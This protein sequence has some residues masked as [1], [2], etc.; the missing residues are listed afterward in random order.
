MI[1]KFCKRQEE[2]NQITHKKEN[3]GMEFEE[4]FSRREK[5][6]FNQSVVNAEERNLKSCAPT[7]C[8]CLKCGL[9]TAEFI[10][11]LLPKGINIMLI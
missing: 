1:T 8:E 9:R 2:E 7:L 5:I 11:P 10:T 6:I 3:R 4:L